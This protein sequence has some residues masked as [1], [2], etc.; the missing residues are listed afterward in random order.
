M[1]GS[2]SAAAWVGLPICNGAE[3]EPAAGA[4][5][6]RSLVGVVMFSLS[7]ELARVDSA[8][9]AASSK[10]LSFAFAW[11]VAGIA[12][13]GGAVVLVLSVSGALLLGAR[14][15]WAGFDCKT[16]QSAISTVAG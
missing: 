14:C 13:F 9:P 2:E 16:R 5:G 6:R 7:A 10:A 11:E 4:V 8:W 3:L 1:A 15:Q 12:G